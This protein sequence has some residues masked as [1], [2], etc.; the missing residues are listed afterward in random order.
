ML[1]GRT[2]CTDVDA[3]SVRADGLH[4]ILEQI[5]EN[6]ANQVRVGIYLAGKGHIVRYQT[7]PFNLPQGDGTEYYD[8]T[9]SFD[10]AKGE[11]R[12]K[13]DRSSRYAFILRNMPAVS[14]V[15]DAADWQYDAE[16]KELLIV[17]EGK[18][19]SLQ[20]D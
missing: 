3:P 16:R 4:R 19:I 9:V 13:S 6:L 14:S 5:D 17:A 11:L 1:I 10:E 12:L 18:D 8:C 20:I 7:Q 2:V 15:K